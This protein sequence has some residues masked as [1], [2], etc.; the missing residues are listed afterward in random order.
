MNDN[1]ITAIIIA[2]INSRYLIPGKD[3]EK[4]AKEIV[5]VYKILKEKTYGDGDCGD[6][7]SQAHQFANPTQ[8]DPGA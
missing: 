8:Y 5:D 7:D 3:N 4:T 1:Q 2:L 6:Y